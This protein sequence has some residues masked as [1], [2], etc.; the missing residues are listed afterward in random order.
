MVVY[1]FG[2]WLW[3]LVMDLWVEFDL[4]WGWLWILMEWFTTSFLDLSFVAMDLVEFCGQW[5][6]WV[7]MWWCCGGFVG[8]FLDLGFVAEVVVVVG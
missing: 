2:L 1:G 5:W 4:Q 8:F 3:S 7:K 6:L